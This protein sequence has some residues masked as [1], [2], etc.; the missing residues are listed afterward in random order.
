MNKYTEIKVQTAKDL[1]KEG[2]KWVTKSIQGTIWAYDELNTSKA[3]W[4]NCTPIF[5]H[6]HGDEIISLESIVQSPILSE[7]ERIFLSKVINPYRKHVTSICKRQTPYYKE[8]I[9]IHEITYH[10]LPD[11]DT[12]TKYKGMEIDKEYT[13]KE[14]GL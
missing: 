5:E 14:L 2:Y 7:E 6:I 10:F 3:K 11:F 8:Y 12:W 4:L 9:E 13:L 1:M